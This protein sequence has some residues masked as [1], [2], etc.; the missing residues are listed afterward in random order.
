MMTTKGSLKIVNFM[1]PRAG[2]LLQGHGHFSKNSDEYALSST[3]SI[4][5]T[6]VT[7]VLRYFNAAF[8]CH[9]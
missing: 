2:F 5:S 3:L 4:Y 7:F 9:C 1:N 8:L 6:L